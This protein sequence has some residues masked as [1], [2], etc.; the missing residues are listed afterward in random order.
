YCIDRLRKR[1]LETVDIQSDEKSVDFDSRF[2]ST[3]ETPDEHLSRSEKVRMVRKALDMLDPVYKNI[4][5]LRELEGLSYDEICE[6][7][8]LGMGTVKSRLARARA[9]L[10]RIL[11]DMNVL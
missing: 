2:A 1:R 7:L 11:T 10:K 5:V 6:S 3:T 8:D 9:E 4:I